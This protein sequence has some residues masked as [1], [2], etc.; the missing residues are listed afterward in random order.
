M[1]VLE[2]SI[3]DLAIHFVTWIL[4]GRNLLIHY[5]SPGSSQGGRAAA[6]TAPAG[7]DPAR[8]AARAQLAGA[9]GAEREQ[10]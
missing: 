5:T 7:E 9:G 1:Y 8:A 10:G 2:H 3:G 6:A 4:G